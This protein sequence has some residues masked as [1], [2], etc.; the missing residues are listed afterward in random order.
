MRTVNSNG[1]RVIHADVRN[2]KNYMEN[3]FDS[4]F[5]LT[6]LLLQIINSEDSGDI[7]KSIEK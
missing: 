7:Q 2:F 1:M 4:I 6:K 5:K 3:E